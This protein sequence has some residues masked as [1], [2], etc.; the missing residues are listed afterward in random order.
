MTGPKPY[1]MY[2]CISM[3]R[4]SLPAELVQVAQ[5]S[6]FSHLQSEAGTPELFNL[7]AE[8]HAMHIAAFADKVCCGAIAHCNAHMHVRD[9]RV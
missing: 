2:E 5:T 1:V 3:C 9:S 6:A 4:N 7:E 8:E